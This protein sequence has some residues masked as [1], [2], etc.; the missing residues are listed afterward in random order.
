MPPTITSQAITVTAANEVTAGA[1][2]AAAPRTM[3]RIAAARDQPDASRAIRPLMMF[4]ASPSRRLLGNRLLDSSGVRVGVER[5]D[6][7]A[8]RS[9]RAHAV[10]RVVERR[11]HHGDAVL[12]RRDGDDAAANAALGRQTG[13]IEP[14]AGVVIE[15]GSRHHREHVRH[16]LRI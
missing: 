4:M 16:V 2:R 5:L 9:L 13:V 12:A 1:T 6:D 3:S 15:T 8:D 14:L 11:R 7:V 10:P